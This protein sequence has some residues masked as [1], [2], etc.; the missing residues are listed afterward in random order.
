VSCILPWKMTMT[1]RRTLSLTKSITTQRVIV[2]H[3]R[4]PACDEPG[5]C[6]PGLHHYYEYAIDT[7]WNLNGLPEVADSANSC[8]FT[9]TPGVASKTFFGL[10]NFIIIPAQSNAQIMNEYNY[11]S[12]RIETCSSLNDDLDVNFIYVDFWNEG[13]LPRLVQERNTAMAL[14]RRLEE[15]EKDA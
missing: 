11:V 12:D 3:H 6:P 9:R 4:G 13:D 15:G 7:Q 14:R 5:T 8:A 2:F 1:T 10:N